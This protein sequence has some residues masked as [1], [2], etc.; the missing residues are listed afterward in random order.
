MKGWPKKGFREIYQRYSKALIGVGD[1]NGQDRR[2]GLELEFIALL[3]P[4]TFDETE[5]FN[6]KLLYQGRPR[7]DAQIKIFERD[8]NSNVS[9]YFLRT[10]ANGIVNVPVKAGF[11]YLLD[12]VILR[13]YKTDKKDAPLWESLWAA[14]TFSMPIK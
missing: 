12:S 13:E 3:N 5:I 1:A 8:P 14:L 4:Y 6:V 11:D 2:F 7:A 9:V 10:D